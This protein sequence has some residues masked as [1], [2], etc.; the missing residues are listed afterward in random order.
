MRQ[1]CWVHTIQFH[2]KI[3][4]FPQLFLLLSEEFHRDPKN[5]FELARVNK[6]SMFK[7]LMFDCILK[8]QN[9]THSS[10][11]GAF[12]TKSFW[13]F[14]ISP[15]KTYVVGTH[16]KHLTD[17]LIVST[18]NICFPGEIRKIFSPYPL[19]SGAMITITIKGIHWNY[20]CEAVPINTHNFFSKTTKLHWQFLPQVSP[21]GCYTEQDLLKR[22]IWW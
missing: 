18:H 19:L 20:L 6:P 15:Q 10:R 11:K 3:R 14:F 21:F 5:E 4:K 22:S 9:L 7:L 2:D 1:F 8:N 17:V 12:S 16:C 13:Y